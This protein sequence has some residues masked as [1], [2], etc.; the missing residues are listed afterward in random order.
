MPIL[1]QMLKEQQEDGTLWTPSKMIA[2]LGKEIDNEDSV[3]Y[4][5]YKVRHKEPQYVVM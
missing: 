5:A 3:Y 1:D 2:R 4:W